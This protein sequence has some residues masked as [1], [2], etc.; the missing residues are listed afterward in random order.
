MG[1]GRRHREPPSLCLKLSVMKSLQKKKKKS[2]A[3]HRK[4]GT[5]RKVKRIHQRH[6][7]RNHHKQSLAF[8]VKTHVHMF[9]C[10]FY[11]TFGKD[12]WKGETREQARGRAGSPSFSSQVP[13]DANSRSAGLTTSSHTQEP[14]PP[15]GPRRGPATTCLRNPEPRDALPPGG[16]AGSVTDSSSTNTPVNTVLFTHRV[17]AGL[18]PCEADGRR[19]QAWGPGGLGDLQGRG[20]GGTDSIAPPVPT[21]T[22]RGRPPG[23]SQ[24]GFFSCQ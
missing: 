20:R 10:L 6:C 4:L 13:S 5:H 8:T 9:T 16:A 21:V 7:P 11:D 15:A 1:A 3:H 12:S 24:A 18:S 14:R 19:A 2:Y 17:P 23:V 22:Q